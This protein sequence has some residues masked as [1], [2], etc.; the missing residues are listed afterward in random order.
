M[1]T[2]T[3]LDHYLESFTKVSTRPSMFGTQYCTTKDLMGDHI[4]VGGP[5]GS[6]GVSLRKTLINNYRSH[7]YVTKSV[8]TGRVIYNHIEYKGY[9]KYGEALVAN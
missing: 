2:H 1:T 5:V 8:S 3:W 7:R 9:K 4:K 6:Q